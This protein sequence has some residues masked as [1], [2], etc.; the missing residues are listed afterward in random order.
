M[1]ID[2][3]GI[4]YCGLTFNWKYKEGYVDITMPGYIPRLLHKY[5]HKK[6]PKPVYSPHKYNAPIY[7]KR[8]QMTPEPDI[9]PKL[10]NKGKTRVQ[11]IIGSL[12]YYTQALDPTFLTALN[13]ISAEQAEP[14]QNTMKKTNQLLDYAATYPHTKLR[15]YASDM[16]L[17][18]ELDAAYLVQPGAKS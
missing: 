14:T 10:D 12:F 4:H 6:P 2:W 17:H 11:S 8:L 16:V 3:T 5:Q 1:L 7:G 9:T 15:Y 13:E 18:I